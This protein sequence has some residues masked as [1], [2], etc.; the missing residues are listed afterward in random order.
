M[1]Y[2]SDTLCNMLQCKHEI[3]IY[4]YRDMYRILYY[5]IYIYMY[6]I[7]YYVIYIYMYMILYYVF[8]IVDVILHL[9]ASIDMFNL[10][11]TDYRLLVS[12]TNYC[13]MSI[14]SSG[15]YNYY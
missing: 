15:L 9:R 2:S 5:V 3:L 12:G 4:M 8:S 1:N 11:A 13:T 7:L 14:G 10:Y 6:M